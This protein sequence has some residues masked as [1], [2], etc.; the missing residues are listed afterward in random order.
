MGNL[1]GRWN[2]EWTDKRTDGTCVAVWWT[3]INVVVFSCNIV[4]KAW[5]TNCE[6]MAS[7]NTSSLPVAHRTCQVSLTRWLSKSMLRVHNLHV[8]LIK[9]GW[10]QVLQLLTSS[11]RHTCSLRYLYT[12]YS[13]MFRLSVI[14]NQ[15]QI[16]LIHYFVH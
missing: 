2:A 13:D 3:G 11:I 12:I 7:C 9:Y 10:T 4:H 6:F 15:L 5:V 1:D 16:E 8:H 14:Q